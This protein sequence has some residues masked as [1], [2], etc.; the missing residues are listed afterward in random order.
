[1]LGKFE[2]G[3]Y[4]SWLCRYTDVVIREIKELYPS[5]PLTAACVRKIK[6]RCGARAAGAQDVYKHGLIDGRL[7]MQ[8][9]SCAVFADPG[10]T[11]VTIN[12]QT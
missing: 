7:L 12:K 8:S 1:M 2:S 9:S 5:L 6:F 4:L 10:L 3:C 11:I